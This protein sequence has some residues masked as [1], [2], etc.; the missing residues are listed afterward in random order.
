[1]VSSVNDLGRSIRATLALLIVGVLGA[2]A[3]SY[4]WSGTAGRIAIN[5]REY[6]L[7]A[8]NQIV[9]PS[10]HDNALFDDTKTVSDPDLLGS[11]DPLTVYRARAAGEPV[12]AILN[13]V[14]PDGYSGAIHLLVGINYDGTVA[15][16][17]VT[18]HH[19]TAGL[20]DRIEI[21]KSDWIKTFAGRSLG[22]PP[23]PAWTVRHDGGAFD[24][25][26][27]ATVTPRAVV[28]AV[29]DA[30]IYFEAHRDELFAGAAGPQSTET[31][32]DE[33]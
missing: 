12:A 21:G 16:V 31:D 11:A 27:G 25:F 30:L 6:S 19:E 28:T 1:M 22:D 2:A 32:A 20:G 33:Q 4:T 15:G 9:D 14:A 18:S 7:R 26:T 24:Q 23:P 8:L 13:V 29:R 17:R 3:V 10:R 5:E